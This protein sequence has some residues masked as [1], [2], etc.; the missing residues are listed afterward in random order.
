[1]PYATA[2]NDFNIQERFTTQRN[3]TNIIGEDDLVL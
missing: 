2:L 3:F 1:M